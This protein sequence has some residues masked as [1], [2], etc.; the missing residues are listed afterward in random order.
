MLESM[1]R[2]R[3]D[4]AHLAAIPALEGCPLEELVEVDGRVTELWMRPGRAL[5]NQRRFAKQLIVLLD[6]TAAVTRGGEP[7]RQIGRGEVIGGSEVRIRGRH[8]VT[9]IT[10]TATRALVISAADLE[11]LADAAPEAFARLTG[12]WRPAAVPVASFHAAPVRR[13]ALRLVPS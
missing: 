13:P 12:S 6:G 7:V 1:R 2:T 8:D 9:I 4:L 11:D 3:T 5:C 10:K